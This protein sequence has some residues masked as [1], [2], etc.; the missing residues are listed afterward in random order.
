MTIMGNVENTAMPEFP[1][2]GFIYDKSIGILLEIVNYSLKNGWKMPEG[3]V[4]I[5]YTKKAFQE[6][7][8]EVMHE[9]LEEMLW[10]KHYNKI[11]KWAEGFPR[12]NGSH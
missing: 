2:I 7:Y 11:V 3:R 9:F 6:C 10:Q 12:L 1:R 5:G 8:W 4:F